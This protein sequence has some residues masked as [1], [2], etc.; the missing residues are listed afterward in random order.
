MISRTTLSD[1]GL[2]G[3]VALVTGAATGIGAATVV[4]LA[5]G[6]AAVAI[7]VNVGESGDDVLARVREHGVDAMVVEADVSVEGD[8]ERMFEE[9]A[10]RLGRVTICVSNAGVQQEATFLDTSFESWRSQIAVN[11]DA[12]FL[13]GRAAARGMVGHGGGTIINVTSVH[14]HITFPGYAPY[15]AAKAGAGMLTKVMAR[16][17]AGDGIRVVAV[18]PGAIASGGNADEDPDERARSESGI[19]AHRLGRPEEVAELIAYLASPE[20]AYITGTTVVIDGAL[21]QQTSTA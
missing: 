21:E 11:L 3:R 4:R 13:V 6:G 15:C 8:V 1:G 17:L 2:V 18:A 20:A 19:P 7:N 10:D 5:G 14:E 9:V 12:T 16:E